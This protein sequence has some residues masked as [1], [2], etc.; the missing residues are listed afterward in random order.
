MQELTVRSESIQ[1]IYSYYLEHTLIVNRRYQRKLVWS[2]EEKASF[3]DSIIKSYPVPLI[4]LAESKDGE[5]TILEIIDGMQRLNAITA[6]IENEFSVEEGYFDLEAIAETK[7][8]KDQNILVQKNPI[9][10]RK[11]CAEIASYVL[12]MSTYKSAS[13]K[14]I[15]EVFRRINANGKHLSRQEIRQA[16]ALSIFADLIRQISSEIR[17]DVSLRNRIALNNMKEI[18]ITSRDLMYGP[19]S[20]FSTN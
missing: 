3:I 6:F 18:S 8:L 16:G 2:I 7:L 14:E 20:R 4:L 10:D 1:R 11:I 13:E 17:G 15:D 19:L 9:M 12:P 5:R